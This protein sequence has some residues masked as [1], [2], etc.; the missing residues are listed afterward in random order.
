MDFLAINGFDVIPGKN[1]EFQKWVQANSQALN[2]N[3]PEGISLV[4]IYASMFGSEK[5]SGQVK[6][7]FRMTSYGDMDKFAAAAAAGGDFARLL[8]EMF[9]FA[10][11]RI[12]TNW[13]NE[14]LKS[15]SDISIWADNPEE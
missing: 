8:D 13:S 15:V 10:D 3:C 12:G 1:V 14:L 6:A 4:G 5:E 9:S 11:A 7:V 2:D